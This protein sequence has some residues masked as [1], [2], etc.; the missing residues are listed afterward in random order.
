MSAITAERG[1]DMA[2]R[3]NILQNYEADL[4]ALM[5]LYQ[6]HLRQHPDPGECGGV[7]SCLMMRTEVEAE[8]AQ[9]RI[10]REMATAGIRLRLEV[11]R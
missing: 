4:R 11:E 2:K 8:Q 5:D 9:E 1:T 7:G 10:L 3:P 6:A